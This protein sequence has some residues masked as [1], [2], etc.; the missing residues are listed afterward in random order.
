MEELEKVSYDLVPAPRVAE[1]MTYIHGQDNREIRVYR[2]AEFGWEDR[3]FRKREFGW[4]R[5]PC[6]Q[7]KA[8]GFLLSTR[9][10]RQAAAHAVLKDLRQPRPVRRAVDDVEGMAAEKKA[11]VI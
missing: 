3:I 7:E 8:Q 6:I 9:E 1:D 11:A 10:G 5:F 4:K 2:L